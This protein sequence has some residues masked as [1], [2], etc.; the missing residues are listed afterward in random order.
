LVSGN[1][2]NTSIFIDTFNQPPHIDDTKILTIQWDLIRGIRAE[3]MREIEVLR[4]AGKVGASLQATVAIAAYGEIYHA[5]LAIKDELKFVFI[6]STVT[7]IKAESITDARITVMP[8]ELAKCERCWH[9][10]DDVGTIAD[11]PTI[12]A[13][14]HTNVVGDGEVRR[15]A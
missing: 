9:Y 5:L 13:R 12:C 11:H 3:V 2:R 6:T 15:F 14:C 1:E 7:L 8:S 4:S 10:T